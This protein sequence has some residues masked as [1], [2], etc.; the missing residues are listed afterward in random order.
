M[1]INHI[2]PKEV[3]QL[4]SLYLLYGEESF[5]LEEFLHKFTE[6]FVDKILP[7]FNYTHLKG[8]DRWP[9]VLQM[10]QTPPVMAPKRIIIFQADALLKQKGEMK[11]DFL[12]YIPSS[13][14]LVI[15]SLQLPDKRLKLYRTIKKHG[16]IIEFKKLK[17]QDVEGWI[18]QQFARRGKRISRGGISL[19]KN[20]FNRNLQRL[21]QEIEKVS[22]YCGDKEEVERSDLVRI[23]SRDLYLKDNLIFDLVDSAG[24]Q[25]LQEG[26]RILTDMNE[27]GESMMGIL[28]M[29]AR[30]FRL[31]LLCK[32]LKGRGISSARAAARL[33]E[34]PYPV[35]KCY[36]QTDNFSSNQ[37][38]TA[39][40]IL[41]QANIDIISGRFSDFLALEIALI[42]LDNL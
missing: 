11:V 30:Q 13:S 38:V 32:E 39:L 25:Q 12:A 17:Y 36:S 8:D 22:L 23:I 14:V 26:L 24:N 20:S 3:G 29:L 37:L 33:G 18:R 34:H 5:L 4:K 19:L 28:S 9:E 27:S 10:V 1:Q 41:L 42:K 35:K 21:E 2:L 16:E 6:K 40:E 7:D 15:Y 31:L